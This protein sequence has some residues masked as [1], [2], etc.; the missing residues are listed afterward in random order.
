MSLCNYH[1]STYRQRVLPKQSA[2]V[3]C[4]ETSVIFYQRVEAIACDHS[5]SPHPSPGTPGPE[6]EGLI[7][8]IRLI[9]VG[10]KRTP[11]VTCLH[12]SL[13]PPL[14][15][16]RKRGMKGSGTSTG[17]GWGIY[18]PLRC[19]TV[20]VIVIDLL[21][22]R[23]SLFEINPTTFRGIQS[24]GRSIAPP[25]T[26]AIVYLSEGRGEHEAL[27]TISSRQGGPEAGVHP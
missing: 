11:L 25:V 7:M 19:A 6:V 18:D 16:D 14:L 24:R 8:S 9:V 20:M 5:K 15:M 23:Q 3:M 12:V 26:H 2:P 13:V 10:G 4:T 1:S 22:S 17:T 27:L 21:S